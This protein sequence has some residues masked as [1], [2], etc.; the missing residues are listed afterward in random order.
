MESV[1]C[2]DCKRAWKLIFPERS[3]KYLETDF[4]L[5][6]ELRRLSNDHYK[7]AKRPS[8]IIWNNWVRTSDMG[9]KFYYKTIDLLQKLN[10]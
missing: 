3:Y 6:G 5:S 4:N 8:Y 2:I 1:F 7:R 9:Y 10:A